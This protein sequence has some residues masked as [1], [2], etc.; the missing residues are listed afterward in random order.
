MDL[1]FATNNNHKLDEIKLALPNINLAGL[2]ESGIN[3]DIPETGT[4]L[5]ENA[6]IKARFI[7]E[8]YGQ[9][10]FADD[11]GLEVEALKG[12][13]GVYS[14]RFAGPSGD[15]K[16]NNEKLLSELSGVKNRKAQ[17]R[18]VICL[19]IEGKEELFEGVCEGEILKAYHGEEGFGYDPLFKPSGHELSFAQ[20]DMKAKNEISHRGLAVKKL[21]SYLKTV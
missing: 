3:V 7:Y 16:K 8:N 12:A 1:I 14:A 10:C 15:F 20:M 2:K 5:E 9:N 21:I 11:T 18:T 19:I 13:P 17:F 6:K 4:S